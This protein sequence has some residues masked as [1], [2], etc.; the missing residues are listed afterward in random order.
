[1]WKNPQAD[2]A[3]VTN[4]H[5]DHTMVNRRP[6]S[7]SLVRRTNA[8]SDVVPRGLGYKECKFS[9]MSEKVGGRNE[10]PRTDRSVDWR[11]LGR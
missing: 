5:F 8:H 6:S 3:V 7:Q 1:M 2:R 10:G 4:R 9:G 11:G